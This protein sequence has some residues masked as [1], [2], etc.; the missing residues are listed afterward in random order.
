MKILLVRKAM[1]NHLIKSTSLEKTQSPVSFFFFFFLVGYVEEKGLWFLLRSKSN[2][3]RG[4][5]VHRH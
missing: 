5:S 3:R 1:G 4:F 2:L